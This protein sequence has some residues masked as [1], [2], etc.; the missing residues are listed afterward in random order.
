MALGMPPPV[1]HNGRVP[2]ISLVFR[3]MW[4][5]ADL[6]ILC[7]LGF[8]SR[9][10]NS[11]G[12]PHLATNE[13]DVGPIRLWSV[14]NY[15]RHLPHFDQLLFTRARPVAGRDILVQNLLELVDDVVPAKGRHQPSVHVNRGLGIFKCAGKRNTDVGML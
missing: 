4:D 3:E 7:Q 15:A 9:G 10:L 6:N 1:R 5:T 12:I 2:H 11:C 13:R 14:G 8:R